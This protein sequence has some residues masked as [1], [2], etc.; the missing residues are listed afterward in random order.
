[1]ELD[2]LAMALEYEDIEYKS[3]Y[4][5]FGKLGHTALATEPIEKQEAGALKSLKLFRYNELGL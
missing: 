1:M 4:E 3:F 5:G 2:M